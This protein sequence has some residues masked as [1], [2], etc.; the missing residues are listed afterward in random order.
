METKKHKLT[1]I[2]NDPGFLAHSATIAFDA[3]HAINR[4]I[5]QITRKKGSNRTIADELR[6]K[7]LET[8]RSCYFEKGRFA[9]PSTLVRAVIEKAARSLKQGP[10]VR[11][12]LWVTSSLGF[13][14]LNSDWS[15]EKLLKTSYEN[16][17]LQHSVPVR[18]GQSRVLRT[19]A[20]FQEW[21]AKYALE[22]DP[23]QV[24]ESQL[25][26]WLRIAGQQIGV[27][28]WRPDKSGP[29]G[30]FRYKLE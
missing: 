22:T 14:F 7:E 16:G 11:R 27:G 28:D 3:S 25:R 17:G 23:E 30:S 4:E 13:D 26:D 18:V 6:I 20:L 15:R 12:G 9:L 19:R 2:G 21:T 5:T 24:D 1:L 8:E 10:Q 29:Y